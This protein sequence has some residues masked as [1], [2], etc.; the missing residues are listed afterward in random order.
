MMRWWNNEAF[1]Q[2][3]AESAPKEPG[4]GNKIGDSKTRIFES[5]QYI[6]ETVYDD[7]TRDWVFRVRAEVNSGEV[8]CVTGNCDTLGNWK[9][10]HVYLLTR[11]RLGEDSG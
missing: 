8:V 6:D 9:H 7:I 3:K 1:L 5:N 2:K 11:E 4:T 10:D